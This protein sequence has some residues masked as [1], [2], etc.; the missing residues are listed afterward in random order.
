MTTPVRALLLCGGKSSRFG[1]DKLLA[2]LDGHPLVSQSARHLMAG[3][4]NAL[5]V[6]P[7]NSKVLRRVLDDAGCKVLESRDC[8]RGMGAS[9][10]AGVRAIPDAG[11][12]IVALG[13]MPFV[14]PLTIAA[15]VD[16]IEKGAL[17][18]A[19][20]HQGIRGHPVGFSARLKD[21][22]MALDGDEGAKRVVAA[23]VDDVQVLLVNDPGVNADVDVPDD[24]VNRKGA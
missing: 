17:I 13:D 19:P 1:A 24:L 15:I 9:L 11:G 16:R 7:P 22:L 10:A 4:G 8:E 18:A 23:H 21:E 12:W 3:A 14:K 6:I 2:D 5:A 20:M